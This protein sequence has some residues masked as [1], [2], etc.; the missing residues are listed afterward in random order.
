LRPCLENTKQKKG[1]GA[2]AQMV[3]NLPN[4]CE[5]LSLNPS[6]IHFED[7]IYNIT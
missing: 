7:L 5:A 6:K 2:V 1:A 4:K 3:E